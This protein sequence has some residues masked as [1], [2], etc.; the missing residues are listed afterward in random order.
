MQTINR[1]TNPESRVDSSG[2]IHSKG[3][4][5]VGKQA[6]SLAEMFYRET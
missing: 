6:F 4:E 5:P 2:G 1:I 3:K